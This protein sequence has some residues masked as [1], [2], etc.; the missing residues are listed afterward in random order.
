MSSEAS[1]GGTPKK[2]PSRNRNRGGRGGR[3]GGRGRGDASSNTSNNLDNA[4]STNFAGRGP[5]HFGQSRSRPDRVVPQ[6]V[7]LDLIASDDEEEDDDHINHNNNDDERKQPAKPNTQQR[8]TRHAH[9]LI[10]YSSTLPSHRSISPCGHD[11]VCAPCLLRLRYLHSDKKCPVCKTTNETIIVDRDNDSL[12]IADADDGTN[13][14]HKRYDQ[15]QQWGQDL[16]TGFVY[17]EDVGMHFPKEY[18]E[19]VVV[20]LFGYACGMPGCGF[21]NLEET[22]VGEKEMR[23]AEGGNEKKGGNRQQGAREVKKRL[24]GQ[25]ALKAHLRTSHGMALCDLCITNKRDFVS[26]LPRFTP[27]GLKTHQSKGDGEMSGFLGHP[28][29]DFCRPLRFYDIVK[30]HEHLNKEHYKC[31]VCDKMGKP[32]QF[33]KDYQSLETHFDRE[34]YLCHDAQCLEARFVVFE[35]EIGLRV[36]EQSVHGATRRDGGTKI[37]L[38]FRVRREGEVLEQQV[39]SSG[40]FQFGL[41]GE[42]FVPDALPGEQRQANE[43]DI[44]DPVHAARTAE[45]RAM[46]ASVR[47]RDGIGSGGVEAFPALG[48]ESAAGHNGML[49]GWSS[50]GVRGAASS[51]LKK[52][53]VGKVTEEEFPS[54]GGG[55]SGARKNRY[56]ALG[57]GR[58]NKQPARPMGANFSAIASRPG[59]ASS[60]PLPSSKPISTVPYSSSMPISRAPDMTKDNFPS[61]GLSNN[62]RPA[63]QTFNPSMSASRAP[64][65]NSDNFPSLGGG[66]SSARRSNASSS[67]LYAAAQA[68]ARK[69]KAGTAPGSVSS[70]SVPPKAKRP[71]IANTLA[72]KKPPPMDNILQFPPPSSQSDSLKTGMDTVGNLKLTLGSVGYKKL[73]TLTKSFASGSTSPEKYVEEAAALFDRGL[74][75]E[76]FWEFVPDL[77][78]SCPNQNGVNSAMRHL[79]AVRVANQMQEMEFGSGGSGAV[80]KKKINYILPKKKA[81][82]SWGNK[83]VMNL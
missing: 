60:G 57:L 73:K 52:T 65:M 18:Y 28:S 12:D 35:N 25:E 45:L 63:P 61:L 49:V 68:H 40:D 67:N 83:K 64:D 33:F 37:K 66:S 30:L 17:R 11:D 36:H 44:S 41:N 2:A 6:H 59:A 7:A 70:S 22:F 13:V 76:S 54:L 10:C 16:G 38:E 39:P 71:N 47:E 58:S 50:D 74:S 4:L 29:C 51:R 72:P 31:H 69:L 48:A 32:N 80:P 24:T 56:Q 43:P 55:T 8:S 5:K 23:E 53:P 34:H 82:S 81:D 20:P 26:K 79:E 9:C 75:D 1:G 19:T 27:S 42:A 77:I 46:A 15:Y 14:H 62:N 21:K 78:R 3:G